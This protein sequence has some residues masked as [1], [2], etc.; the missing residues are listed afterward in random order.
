MLNDTVFGK[1]DIN[2]PK[3]PKMVGPKKYGIFIFHRYYIK[4]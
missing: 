4:D 1:A 2:G 3:E